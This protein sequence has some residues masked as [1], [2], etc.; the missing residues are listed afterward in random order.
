MVVVVVVVVGQLPLDEGVAVDVVEGESAAGGDVVDA[1]G[2]VGE[3]RHGV[4]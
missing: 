2:G 4:M 1:D 3:F